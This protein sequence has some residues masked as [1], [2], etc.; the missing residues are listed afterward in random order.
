MYKYFG[1]RSTS[2]PLKKLAAL[3]SVIC[4]SITYIF[5]TLL[6]LKSLL[7]VAKFSYFTKTRPDNVTII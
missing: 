7:R 5:L 3:I 6:V 4:I 1:I 2:L